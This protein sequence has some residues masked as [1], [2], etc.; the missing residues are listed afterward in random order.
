MVMTDGRHALRQTAGMVVVPGT[1][2]TSREFF[3]LEMECLWPH[4]WQVACREEEI[5]NPGDFFEYTIGDQ[6]IL[7]VRS[8]AHDI[9][10]FF[11]ACPHRGTRLVSGVGSFAASQIRC[12]YH[13]WRW[14]FEGD[15]SEVVDRHDFPSDDDR[16]SGLPWPI[17]RSAG[18][19]GSCSSTWTRTGNPSTHSSAP[20]PSGSQPTGFRICGF[21][22]TGRSSSSATGKR[23]STPSTRATTLRLS[24]RRC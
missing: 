11:N 24:T 1:R 8:D 7:V 6:S 15:I 19:A 20:F 22:R 14:S 12:P 4:V 2:Y 23:R 16:R 17:C 18:G 10:A 5:P 9:R 13:G 3:D 21:A